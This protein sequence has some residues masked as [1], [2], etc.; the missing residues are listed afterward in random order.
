MWFL[1][2][3]NQLIIVFFTIFK[4]S[5]IIATGTLAYP[6]FKLDLINNYI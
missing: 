6:A 1:A 3:K 4:H 2:N 5:W